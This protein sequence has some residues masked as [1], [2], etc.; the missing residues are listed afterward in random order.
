MVEDRTEEIERTSGSDSRKVWLSDSMWVILLPA[1]AYVCAFWSQKSYFSYYGVESV[2]V[3]PSV[4]DVVSSGAEMIAF[5]FVSMAGV[6]NLPSAFVK[7]FFLLVWY[8]APLLFLALICYGVFQ[9]SGFSW[10]FLVFVGVF[11]SISFM[12]FVPL[13]D[14]FR[15]RVGFFEL[16]SKNIKTEREVVS[17]SV[18][19]SISDRVPFRGAGEIFALIFLLYAASSISGWREARGQHELYEVVIDG[20]PYA[21]L[22]SAAGGVVAAGVHENSGGERVFNG[23]ATWL[24]WKSLDGKKLRLVGSIS[25]PS[26]DE[27]KSKAMRRHRVSWDELLRRLGLRGS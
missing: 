14:V 1:V 20:V 10:G 13:F 9:M 21:L 7:K 19:D 17:R 15:G 18:I 25:K 22:K 11:V 6:F 5:L 27:H 26:D 24:S 16:I 12:F 8:L 4:G 3:S 2:F 23:D